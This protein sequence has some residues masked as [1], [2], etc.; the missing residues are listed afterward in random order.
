MSILHM[1]KETI[2]RGVRTMTF[3][4]IKKER[5]YQDDRKAKDYPKMPCGFQCFL[6]GRK[7]AT[8]EERVQHL[9]KEPHGG[10]YDTGSPQ[11]RED[12][13]RHRK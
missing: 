7:F 2:V 6:C 8:D 13:R 3:L 12:A 4:Q 1:A 10:M 9:E 5:D 11:E